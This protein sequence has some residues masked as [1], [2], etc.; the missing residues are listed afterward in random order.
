[1]ANRDYLHS[2]CLLKDNMKVFDKVYQLI[3]DLTNERTEVLI[4]A[5]RIT[6][7]EAQNSIEAESSGIYADKLI[8]LA[9]N[10][11]EEWNH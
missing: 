1:M 5:L 10:I 11:I 9:N 3:D 7:K 8:D 2:E 4:K 6:D